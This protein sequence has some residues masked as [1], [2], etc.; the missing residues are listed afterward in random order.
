MIG[1]DTKIAAMGLLMNGNREDFKMVSWCLS[2]F[3]SLVSEFNLTS[4]V[5]PESIPFFLFTRR[6][7]MFL[8]LCRI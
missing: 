7:G 2:K 5:E 8:V 1:E 3:F 6:T 4:M